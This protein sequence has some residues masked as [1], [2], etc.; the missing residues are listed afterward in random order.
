MEW[1]SKAVQESS[2]LDSVQVKAVGRTAAISNY[3]IERANMK[4]VILCESQGDSWVKINGDIEIGR[5]GH[6][7]F[8]ETSPAV[9][10]VYD[11]I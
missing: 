8:N 9:L 2:E 4:R 6:Y 10:A 5:L 11:G 3:R 1:Y 7:G